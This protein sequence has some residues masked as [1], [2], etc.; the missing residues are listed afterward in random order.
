MITTIPEH[1]AEIS[2]N[3]YEIK[4]ICYAVVGF[5]LGWIISKIMR[6]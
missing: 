2:S 6:G 3:I 1:L 5:S 4:L